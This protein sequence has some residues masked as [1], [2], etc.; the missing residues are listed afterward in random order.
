MIAG[1]ASG[2]RNPLEL[3]VHAS[4]FKHQA[5]GRPEDYYA[6]SPALSFSKEKQSVTLTYTDISVP[7]VTLSAM[8]D[9][10]E[11]R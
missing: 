3:G 1:I 8:G 11:L 5:C 10:L 4:L 2:R 9:E 7:E 6:G